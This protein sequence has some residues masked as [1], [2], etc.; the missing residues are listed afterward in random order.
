M[1]NDFL[2]RN[3][4]CGFKK[5][6]VIDY[7]EKIKK[8]SQ[9]H[10]VLAE[11]KDND[12]NQANSKIADL[13][14]EI[15]N[16]KGNHEAKSQS[17]MVSK[18]SKS[19]EDFYNLKNEN[20]ILKIQ[21]DNLTNECNK[22]KK[23]NKQFN[24]LILDAYIHSEDILKDARDKAKNIAQQTQ[25]VI[26]TTAVDIEDFSDY[27]NNISSDFSKIVAELTNNIKNLTGSLITATKGIKE[28][29]GKDEK[30]NRI[31][32]S[33]EDLISKYADD[34]SNDNQISFEQINPNSLID[35]ICQKHDD[36]SSSNQVQVPN[37]F[38]EHEI[39]DKI[40]KYAQQDLESKVEK[41]NNEVE[42]KSSTKVKIKLKKYKHYEE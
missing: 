38:S 15:D 4:F 14:K 28:N 9:H 32:E 42:V 20:D 7:I 30:G 23:N 16:L 1:S 39:T 40:D 19:S 31:L 6:D 13:E 25:N 36:K 33:F 17:I 26:N 27:V 5:E 8:E 34:D 3:S 10:K 21:I 2:I 35:D 41:D 11:S 22:F 24:S 12:L 29:D 37:K 18:K